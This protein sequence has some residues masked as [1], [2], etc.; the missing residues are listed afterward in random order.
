M[1]GLSRLCSF[2][3]WLLF[4]SHFYHSVLGCWHTCVRVATIFSSSASR[5]VTITNFNYNCTLRIISSVV[6]L[7]K[8]KLISAYFVAK[9]IRV[10]SFLAQIQRRL[11]E[12][13]CLQC[14]TSDTFSP[15]HSIGWINGNV[16]KMITADAFKTL[17]MSHHQVQMSMSDSSKSGLNCFRVS[18]FAA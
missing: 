14:E 4:V 17:S 15:L 9:E 13:I 16:F 8:F 10:E 5:P 11:L 12:A 1:V 18:Q 3:F 7:M 2:L 6:R